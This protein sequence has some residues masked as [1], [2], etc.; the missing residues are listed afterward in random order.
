MKVTLDEI[1][2][3]VPLAQMESATEEEFRMRIKAA[4]EVELPHEKLTLIPYLGEVD[5]VVEYASEELI[6]L[7]PVTFLPDLYKIR[8]RFVPDEYIPEL[9]TVKQYFT[10]YFQLPISHEH[11]AARIHQQFG[12]QVQPKRLHVSLDVAV[13]GGI[14]TTVEVGVSL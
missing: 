3:W 8:I 14:K 4:M 6:G 1:K 7:C 5:E 10:D 12:D 13:R 2:K 9:K 11:L